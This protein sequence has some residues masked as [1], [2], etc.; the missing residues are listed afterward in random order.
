MYNWVL[1][2]TTEQMVKSH[3]E[4][5]VTS[6]LQDPQVLAVPAFQAECLA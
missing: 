5:C 6:A 3:G 1:T 2:C 4:S